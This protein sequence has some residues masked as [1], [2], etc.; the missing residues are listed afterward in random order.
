MATECAS[1]TQ[2]QAG[3]SATFVN[4]TAILDRHRTLGVSRK[5]EG[6][7]SVYTFRV[8]APRADSVH[9]VGDFVGWEKGRPMKALPHGIWEYHLATE[10]S[11]EGMKYKYKLLSRA[12]PIYYTDPYAWQCEADEPFASIVCTKSRFHFQDAVWCLHRSQE[13]SLPVTARPFHVYEIDPATWRTHESRPSNEAF[14]VFGYRELADRLTPYV[15]GLGYTYIALTPDMLTSPACL[16]PSTRYGNFDDF[17]YLVNKLHTNGVG[18]LFPFPLANAKTQFGESVCSY[19]CPSVIAHTLLALSHYSERCHVDGFLLQNA[20]SDE[21]V[22]L[23]VFAAQTLKQSRPELLF[24]HKGS[25]GDNLAAFDAVSDGCKESALLRYFACDPFF[26]R[27]HHAA[28]AIETQTLLCEPSGS[29]RTLM[30]SLFG[31]Y[32]EKFAA[33]RLYHTFRL[34][35]PAALLSCMGNELAPFAPRCRDRELEWFLLDFSMHRHYFDFVKKANTLYLENP[36]LYAGACELLY[37]NE[38]DNT[39]VLARKS[40]DKTLL[41]VFNFSAVLLSDYRLPIQTHACREIFSSDS[42]DFGGSGQENTRNNLVAEGGVV[43]DIPPLSAV[44]LEM[45][46]TDS[47]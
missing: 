38:N 1:H 5:D 11:L 18:I 36:P 3:Q 7:L 14:A 37:Q 30:S 2:C 33:M 23:A 22:S 16:S 44:V 24:L 20:P 31:R 6:S 12:K 39:L 9:L 32:E 46:Q 13:A 19:S 43:L 8:W 15:K 35:Y 10:T 28:L 27:Y 47:N 45:N 29:E 41:G 40:Q 4:D 25:V 42:I 26:R 17:L 21:A 34:F